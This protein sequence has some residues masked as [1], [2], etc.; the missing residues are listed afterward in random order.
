MLK[1]LRPNIY[2]LI[3]FYSLAIALSCFVEPLAR[4]TY[5]LCIYLD[6]FWMCLLQSVPAEDPIQHQDKIT[7]T[8][9]IDYII[10]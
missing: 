8:W 10:K 4:R 6:D 5:H 7:W 1:F 9:T 3:A 2:E